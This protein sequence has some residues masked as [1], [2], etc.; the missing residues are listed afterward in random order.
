MNGNLKF[1]NLLV[2]ILSLCG[3]LLLPDAIQY[4]GDIFGLIIAA[5]IISVIRLISIIASLTV[6]WL[7]YS[8]LQQPLANAKE[9]WT[10]E[11]REAYRQEQ[12]AKRNEGK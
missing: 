11:K 2:F 1:K 10:P 9:I 6:N 3:A 8:P 7:T 5:K 12:E 4:I